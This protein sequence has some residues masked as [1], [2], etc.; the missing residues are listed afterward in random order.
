MKQFWDFVNDNPLVVLLIVVL[1]VGAIVK[2]ITGTDF[3][4]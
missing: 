2:I 4:F 3:K 1:I